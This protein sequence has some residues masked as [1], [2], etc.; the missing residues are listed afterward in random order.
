[1]RQAP[2]ELGFSLVELL[3]VVMLM[4]ILTAMAV[5]MSTSAVSGYRLRSESRTIASLVGLAK[6]RATA[7]LTRS[8]VYAD[9]ALHRYRLEIWNKTTNQWAIEGGTTQMP[10]S[11]R[12]GFGT[13]ALAP[14]NTQGA[15]GQSLP[16]KADNT[17]TDIANTACLV[18]NSRGIPI[19]SLGA[20]QGGNAFYITDGTGVRATTVT[21]TPLIREWWS[22]AHSAQWVRQ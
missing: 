20:P 2:N 17:V 11:V 12:F 15:I 6:L 3:V 18:F 16:C 7:N 19:N 8:R 10:T 4:A 22:P 13:L 9:L 14:P 1:M 5:P 21:A